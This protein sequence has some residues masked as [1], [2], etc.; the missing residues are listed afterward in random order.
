LQRSALTS[1][2]TIASATVVAVAASTLTIAALHPGFP[3]KDVDLTSRDVWVT[4]GVELLGGRLNKQI[5]E[6]DGS[7]QATSAAF[8]VLQDGDA[9]F[10]VDPDADR[11][12][13]VDPATTSVTS[14]IELPDGAEV[15]FGGAVV[16][17]LAPDGRL[18]A[19]SSVGDLR[20]DA[21][22][23]PPVAE[24]G[25]DAH[26]TVTRDGT[27][28]A[29]SRERGELVRLDTLASTPVV[30]PFPK[31]GAFQLAAVGD[32]PVV[33]D[34]STNDV[35]LGDGRTIPL[36]DDRGIR[37]QQTGPAATG[38]VVATTTGLVRVVFESGEVARI[39][40]GIEADASA[41]AI[42]A[43]V[44]VDGCAHGAWG[45][46]QRY[47]LA[48]EGSDPVA[49]SIAE[50]AGHVEFRVNRSVVVLNDLDSGDVWLPAENMRLVDNWDD[51]TPPEQQESEE[52][53]DERS[54][55]QSFEDA[56]AE[57]S[58]DN[59]PPTA[60][61][62]EFGIRP[63][64]TTILPVLDNDS[65]PDGDVLVIRNPT[66]IAE[67]TGR[68]ELIDG[69]R[70]LQFTPA[71][72][73]A[74]TIRFDY[75]VDDGRGGTA[76]A[77]ATARIVAEDQN[78]IPVE[79]RRSGVSVEANRTVSYN[80]LANWRD[81]DGD[82]L[83]I[84][85]A[86]PRSGDLVRF[87]PD[88][89]ITF[90]HESSELG[91]KEVV[92]QVSDG[93]GETVAGTLVVD[94]Q[95]TGSLTP[96]ATPDFATVFTGDAVVIA[97]LANDLSPSGA[98]LV[99]TGVEE[100]RDGSS[101]TFDATRGEVRFQAPEAG[102]RYVL[103]TVQASGATSTGIIRV[104]VRD[105][106]A[107]EQPP[108]A[109]K[110]TAFLRPGE[111]VTVSVL[112]NDVSP[113]GRILAVQSV[114]VPLELQ[115]GGLVV[116]LL[117]STLVRVTAPSALTAPVAFAYT[118]SDGVRTSSAAVTI[119]PVPALTVH[120]PP[121]A[122]DDRAT[123]RAGDIVTVHVLDN[124]THPDDVAMSVDP[125]LLAE[126]SAGIA[127]VNGDTVRF[128]APDEPGE[129]RA[130]YRVIDPFGESA[131][132]AVVFT[133]TPVDES[134]N[135]D[136]RPVPVVARVL[137]GNQVRI[138]LPL[139]GID[140]D[141]DSVQ[142]LRFPV[143]PA[144][145]TVVEKGPDYLVYEAAPGGSGTDSFTYQV[146]DA[147]GA[148]GTGDIDIAVIPPPDALS[149]PNAVPDSVAVRPGRIAQVDLTANDSDPQGSAIEVSEELIDVPGELDATVVD[150]RYLQL[151][152]PTVEG[153]FS[154]RYELTNA[155][156]GSATTFVLIQVAAD[157]P[158]TPPHAT[159]VGLTL[160]QIAGKKSLEVDLFDGYAFN[161]AG[162]NSVLEL[163]LDGPNAAEA[164]L[165]EGAH[166]VVEVRPG[167]VRRA[168]AYRLTDPETGL[169]GSAFIIV[170]AAVDED[171]DAE[172]YID[173]ALPTQYVPMNERREW[174]LA[175][176]VIV[177]SGRE[178]WMPDA[179]SVR[180]VQ[181][182]GSPAFVDR[183]TIAFQGARDYRG[184]ASITFLVTDGASADD[185]QGNT[186]TLT[187]PI[188]VG[189]P[190]FRDTP[191]EF[192]PPL[193]RLEA[194]EAQTVDLRASTAHP[195]AQILREVT[196]SGLTGAA[197]GI[198]AELS[199]STLTIE[200]PRDTPKGTSVEFG[201]TLRWGEFTV[202]GVVRVVVVGSS[203]P[204]PVAAADAFE[205]QHGDGTVVVDPLA[206]DFNPYAASGEPLRLIGA[207]LDNS[208]AA[209]TVTVS[210]DQVRITPNP[211]LK[212]GTVVVVYTI[213]D[214]T[215][216]PDRRVNGTI[217]VVVSDV[218]D[219]PLRPE[220]DGGSAVGGDGTAT[221]RFQAPATNGKPI[222]A[223]EIASSPAVT[224][225][226]D[227][228][229]GTACTITGLANGTA[230]SFA[231]RAVNEHGAGPWSPT[232]EPITP[233]GTPAQPT[234]TATASDPW[235]GAGSVNPGAITAS[236]PDIAGTG[237]TTTYHWSASNGAS[238]TTTGLSTGP[239]A[240]PAG[241]YTISV[242][243][244][245]DGHKTGP[246]GVSGA[247]DVVQQSAPGAPASISATVTD[248]DDPGAAK[249][250]WSA[251]TAATGGSANI[252]YE[253]QY[254]GASPY[255]VG[256]S[257][258][259][260]RSDLPA[261]TRTVRVRAVNKA[262]PGPWSAPASVSIA[263]TNTTV[264]T[265]ACILTSSEFYGYQ[266]CGGHGYL[267]AGERINVACRG[268]QSGVWFLYISSGPYAGWFIRA[269]ETSWGS[270]PAIGNC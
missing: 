247:V 249:W 66:P 219:Q 125:E 161:P 243:A 166:G 204:L 190:E 27:V 223:Y 216:D 224:T 258:S 238:G 132:A 192:T 8:D 260:S 212:A 106:P 130:D 77:H 162:P 9:L 102:I 41:D 93:R 264:T 45:P 163:V 124:D 24:L 30:S 120:Q 14:S 154:L 114:E 128:Q 159:D 113:A 95:P 183:D 112:S 21:T 81:P 267:D 196:Y 47:V 99:L 270:P 245:N 265:R 62:D 115:A 57:R 228:T 126:P 229:A 222:T 38:A 11:L 133:V 23:T 221:I 242:Y 188:V 69:G 189:D 184:P 40:A 26:A 165:V 246:T 89:Y 5:D 18:W 262:G 213:E 187:L 19:I 59:R 248:G 197:S 70:A 50:P 43:P 215:R 131:G 20:F 147:F 261:G 36:G 7:V 205:T 37:L 214:A 172:P 174:D 236:W 104:D 207:E 152:A 98:D 28:L 53:G 105:R 75:T 51:V 140:P 182:D 144:L 111:P 85:S 127:F 60:G 168:I 10:L 193:V 46:A 108:I 107:E 175:D 76:T 48:C 178:A 198:S 100:P 194:G 55:Q 268:T 220:R 87:T 211:T 251:A 84:V 139:D 169:S 80:V 42:A 156:G 180:A 110:D 237:G 4:N 209:G 208:G 86:S 191:P 134:A 122:R 94:V 3:V 12:D 231:V 148:T 201:V 58:D 227:C 199:G 92:F 129:Y 16:S 206:N 33:L 137:A 234:V 170:P 34:E 142:L 54:A 167:S 31:V 186:V 29:V 65:D 61:D 15:A 269:T 123:V 153:S 210:G 259:Y 79:L 141:G 179:A 49:Q 253:V 88:G 263:S 230:Y 121:L 256:V 39:P 73:F 74:S 13:S 138:D 200:S 217:T 91:E 22:T 252:T 239:I 181:S 266:S 195:N 145:G 155:R 158:L 6:L 136:P 160:A 257:T 97:P 44:N 56:L 218:P 109:V 119:V 250:T 151:V 240:V 67:A 135:R 233:Y 185:P 101:V 82:D 176:I 202:P 1:R 164:A 17:I 72:G 149:A 226:T 90:T 103:Y 157:A 173:P 143:A 52:E 25:A 117:Q 150:G 225:P 78:G 241:S 116:E 254:D 83:S 35:V 203:R 32:E 171:F 232:S 146:Y 68:L 235:A 255:S 63:G 2:R 118:V 71:P 64:R 96:V 177:P 244:E